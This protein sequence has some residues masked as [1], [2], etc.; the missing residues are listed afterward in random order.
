MTRKKSIV[1]VDMDDTAVD[2]SKQWRLYH[3]R[4]PEYQYPQSAIGFFATM[5][6]LP[7]F[8]EAWKVL[9]EYYDMR[10]LT[11]PSPYN[12]NSYTEKAQWV[13]DNM[14]GIDALEKLN[15]CPDKSLLNGA[16]L[17]DDWNVHGQT[18]FEGEHI[19]FGR[20]PKFKN[21]K[22]VTEYLLEKAGLSEE[23]IA[24]RIMGI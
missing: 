5:E 16:Y 1:Y 9:S 24:S 8:M 15:L 14:G 19:H 23:G 10:F 6:P 11:R 12:I 4:Y 13:R 17:I 2:Y 21:W 20:D 3:A 22:V 18:E 7:G